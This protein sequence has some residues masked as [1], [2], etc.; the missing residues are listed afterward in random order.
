VQTPGLSSSAGFFPQYSAANLEP[1]P[2][3]LGIAAVTVAFTAA[4]LETIPAF[5]ATSPAFLET[6]A[7][8]L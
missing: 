7:S 5:P 6:A 4:N 2:A 1:H 8:I 3:F